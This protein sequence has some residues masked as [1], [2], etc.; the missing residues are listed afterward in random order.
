MPKLQ[1]DTE[2]GKAFYDHKNQPGSKPRGKSREWT[3]VDTDTVDE[4][5]KLRLAFAELVE[6]VAL[7]ENKTGSPV[8]EDETY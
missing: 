7:L 2:G 8:E 3:P 6:R 4:L 5:D 1:Q